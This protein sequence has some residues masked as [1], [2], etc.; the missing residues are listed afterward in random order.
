MDKVFDIFKTLILPVIAGVLIPL[1]L[2]KRTPILFKRTVDCL[3]RFWAIFPFIGKY[4]VIHKAG[5]HTI[6]L[7]QKDI[8]KYRKD[9]DMVR[10][11]INH[12]VDSFTYVGIWLSDFDSYDKLSKSLYDILCEH[13]HIVVNLYFRNPELTKSDEKWLNVYYNCIDSKENV[14][15]CVDYWIRWKSSM[16]DP[17]VQDRIKIYIH[18]CNLTCSFFLFNSKYDAK[19]NQ[20]GK[21]IIFFDQKLFGC[22]KQD[23]ISMEINLKKTERAFYKTIAD[24]YSKVKEDS[25]LCDQKSFNNHNIP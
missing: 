22:S 8:A 16:K 21:E 20:I 6:F 5:I 18:S 17:H 14:K 2:S 10:Y 11:I 24:M 15:K 12:T 13:S 4:I 19:I 3:D 1:L 7:N 9:K 25:E 23:S